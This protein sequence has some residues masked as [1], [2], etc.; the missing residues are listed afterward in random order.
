M[1]ALLVK[2]GRRAYLRDEPPALPALD[3]GQVGVGASVHHNLVQHF[4]HI[5]RCRTV[6]PG[7]DDLAVQS[8]AQSDVHPLHARPNVRSSTLAPSFLHDA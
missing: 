4:I 7:P 5:T 8:H 1:Q 3:F 2:S 6:L